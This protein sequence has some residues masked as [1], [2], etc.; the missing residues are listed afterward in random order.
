MPVTVHCPKCNASISI[1]PEQSGQRVQC[2]TCQQ[3]FLAPNVSPEQAGPTDEDDDWL[4][5]DDTAPPPKP[6]TSP[7]SLDGF[8]SSDADARGEPFGQGEHV[9]QTDDVFDSHE[10]DGFGER[11]PKPQQSKPQPPAAEALGAEESF[12]VKCPICHSVLYAKAKQAGHN[13]RCN[14]C[15]S[16]IVVPQPPKNK[17][18]PAMSAD[19]AE[20]FQFAEQQL[21]ER[22]SDPFQRSAD[23]LLK[24]AEDDDSDDE[25]EEFEVQDLA[26]WFNTV[27]GIFLD[28]GVIIHLLGLSLLLAVPAA[29]TYMYPVF[30]LGM[31]PLGLIGIFV[32]TACGFAILN[33]VANGHELIEDWPTIDPAGW[34]ESMIPVIAAIGIAAGPAYM[35]TALMNATPIITIGVV[36]FA[37]Y[38]L[39]PFILLSMLDMQSVT[40]PFSEDVGKS[41]NKCQQDWIAFYL[42]SGILFAALFG[43]F[44]IIPYSAASIG[45]GVT[46]AIV[47]A[48]MYF[49]LLG[50]LA[51]AIG[52][53]AA[54]PVLEEEPQAEEDKSAAGE[55]KEAGSQ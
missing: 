12:R 53:I 55:R 36:M 18:A 40:T 19:D 47:V 48:F 15:Y 32:T 54:L 22:R 26:G 24:A 52:E 30:G 51:L 34:A 6:T 33:A 28:P 5:L 27:L 8:D 3:P 39:F 4:T 41:I 10:E 31:F 49:A 46:L 29:L 11:N 42:A 14:D 45:I 17:T 35:I 16:D 44:S 13:I 7:V 20:S 1:N 38:M 9:D 21:A 2:P 25:D 43:Y 50:R 23:E 37:I